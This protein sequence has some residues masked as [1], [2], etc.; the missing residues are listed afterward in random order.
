MAM[1]WAHGQVGPGKSEL[2][3]HGREATARRPARGERGSWRRSVGV[4][5]EVGFKGGDGYSG[6][7]KW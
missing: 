7:L 5:M 4:V 6:G 3:T 1:C 2:A